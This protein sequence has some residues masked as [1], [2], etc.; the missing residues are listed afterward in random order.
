MRTDCF[1]L[2][3]VGT[4]AIGC[5]GSD[6]SGVFTAATDAAA[7]GTTAGDGASSSGE[8]GVSPDAGW[9]RDGGAGGEAGP[10]GNTAQLPCGSTSCN[11]PGETCC[12][13]RPR[14]RPPSFTYACAAGSTCPVPADG[15]SAT[16]LAC[17]SAAN[18]APGSVCCVRDDGQRVWSECAAACTGGA[19]G[20]ASAQLCDPTAPQVG[21]AANAPCSSANIADWGLPQGFGT[22]GGRGN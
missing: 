1:V 19:G 14:S 4:A 16:E 17:S 18:C 22:C 12:V 7:D 10:G 8:G 3:I 13:V 2:V 21:C 11:I 5:G 20:V 15:G 9:V 6:A